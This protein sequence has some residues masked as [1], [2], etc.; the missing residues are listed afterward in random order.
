VDSKTRIGDWEADTVVERRSKLLLMAKINNFTAEH[1]AETIV[2]ML[3]RFQRKLHTITFD[4]GLEFAQH[5]QLTARFPGL[6]TYFAE[7]YK[8]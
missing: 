1:V 7:P 6:K 4:N 2:K 8:S 5:T 3:A